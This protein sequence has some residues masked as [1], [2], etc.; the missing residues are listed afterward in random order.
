V[1]RLEGAKPSVKPVNLD[2][3]YKSA[4]AAQNVTLQA[5]DVV[6]VPEQG[7]MGFGELLGS[8]NGLAYIF[9]LLK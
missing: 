3:F 2:K 1:V 9:L 8:L 6:Y 7:G 4:D 5:G